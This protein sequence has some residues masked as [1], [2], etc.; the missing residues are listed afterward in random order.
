MYSLTEEIIVHSFGLLLLFH[1]LGRKPRERDLA[2]DNALIRALIVGTIVAN[3]LFTLNNGTVGQI[4]NH[5]AHLFIGDF[6]FSCHD[7]VPIPLLTQV[8]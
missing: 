5:H 6:F 8:E 4:V 3:M 7:K 1:W 2:G